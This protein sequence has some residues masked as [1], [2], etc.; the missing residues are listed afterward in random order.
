MPNRFNRSKP[1]MRQ[2]FFIL[3][4][5]DQGINWISYNLTDALEWLMIK[6]LTLKKYGAFS[7]SVWVQVLYVLNCALCYK[8]Y[9]LS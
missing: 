9:I 1:A 3:I 2:C 5:G 8:Y 6:L 4:P 7:G